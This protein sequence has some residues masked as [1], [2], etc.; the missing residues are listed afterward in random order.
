[1]EPTRLTVHCQKLLEDSQRIAPRGPK[2]IRRATRWGLAWVLAG[3]SCSL[4]AGVAYTATNATM[5]G[6]R[7]LLIDNSWEEFATAFPTKLYKRDVGDPEEIMADT[8]CEEEAFI[9]GLRSRE[10][11]WASTASSCWHDGRVSPSGT[12]GPARELEIALM[13]TDVDTDVD[14]DTGTDTDVE[15]T[16]I[17]MVASS[18]LTSTPRAG[19]LKRPARVNE[20][21]IA[22]VANETF[23]VAD[24]ST[25]IANRNYKG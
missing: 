19:G 22:L 18:V 10:P 1:M 12:Q 17:T 8:G 2:I 21:K 11:P 7:T 23:T 24:E 14:T 20:S 9:R 25:M 5:K 3:L 6:F 15:V 16:T 4:S 13:D